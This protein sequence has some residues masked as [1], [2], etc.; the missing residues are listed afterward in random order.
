MKS[1]DWDA[2]LAGT[3]T[4]LNPLPARVY[5][6]LPLDTAINDPRLDHP[7]IVQVVGEP[8]RGAA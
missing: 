4:A 5:E 1:G 7:G 2:W 3:S 8:V 6:V